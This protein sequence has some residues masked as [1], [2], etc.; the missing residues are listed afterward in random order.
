MSI[1]YTTTGI[2]IQSKIIHPLKTIGAY[3]GILV[4]ILLIIFGLIADNHYTR[5]FCLVS[6]CETS[7]S[8]VRNTLF[9]GVKRSVS[10]DETP[11]SWE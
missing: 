5:T 4:L 8:S 10:R 11:C 6:R 3:A 9:L 7:C 1:K 2:K